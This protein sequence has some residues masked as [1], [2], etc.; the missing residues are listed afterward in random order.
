MARNGR[1]LITAGHGDLQRTGYAVL[2]DGS[3]LEH[4]APFSVH[5]SAIAGLLNE[6]FSFNEIEERI[7]R[8]VGDST[9]DIRIKQVEG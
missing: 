6:Q 3:V 1:F 2:K 5:E 7:C 4:D 8:D 9:F